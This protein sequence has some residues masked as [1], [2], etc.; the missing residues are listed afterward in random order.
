MIVT[1]PPPSARSNVTNKHSCK[2]KHTEEGFD[3]PK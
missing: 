3:W 2:G 1:W